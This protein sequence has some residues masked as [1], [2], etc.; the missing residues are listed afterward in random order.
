[1]DLGIHYM[2]RHGECSPG[3]WSVQAFRVIV[4]FRPYFCMSKHVETS[5]TEISPS[6]TAVSSRFEDPNMG[7]LTRKHGI[8]TMNT[9][10][11]THW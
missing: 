2:T 3:F 8:F 9:Q 6:D 1:M 10:V 11:L 4:V 7:T 5:E